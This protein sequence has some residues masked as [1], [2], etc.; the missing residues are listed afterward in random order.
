MVEIL[1]S[2]ILK[3]GIKSLNR[4]TANLQNKKW[5]VDHCSLVKAFESAFTKKNIHVLTTVSW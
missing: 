1:Q 3:T 5:L 2:T 4:L